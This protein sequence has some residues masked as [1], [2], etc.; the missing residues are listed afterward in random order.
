[1]NVL[2]SV[3]L[4]QS[5]KDKEKTG[6]KSYSD[7]KKTGNVKGMIGEKLSGLFSEE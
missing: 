5:K 3:W 6:D 4:E 1:M 7:Y 2:D